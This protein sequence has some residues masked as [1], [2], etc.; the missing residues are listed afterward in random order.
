MIKYDLFD[1]DER[2]HGVGGFRLPDQAYATTE[3]RHRVQATDHRVLLGDVL[4]DLRF[5]AV[6]SHRV[7]GALPQGPSVVVPGAFISGA[8]QTFTR[9]RSISFQ[10]QDI[11]SLTVAAH[12]VRLGARVKTRRVDALDATNFGGTFQFQ[13]LADFANGTPLLLVRRAGN[14]AVSFNDT[15]ANLFAEMIF[16]PAETV[17]VT[18][19]LRYDWQ[20]RVPDWNNLGPRIAAAFAPQGSKTVYRAG[21]GVFYQSLSEDAVARALLF[22]DGGLREQSIVAPSFPSLPG[23]GAADGPASTWRLEPGMSAPMLVQASIAADRALWRKSSLSV[24]YLAIRSIGTLRARDVN[25]PLPG[26]L[27]RPDPSRLGVFQIESSGSGR[28]DALSTTFRG[29]LAGFRGTIQYTLSHATDEGAGVFD[30]PAD[31]NDLDAERGRADTDRRHR[32]SVAGTHGWLRDRL[33]LG[34][35]LAA[36]SGAP[37][38]IVTGADTNHDLLVNDRPSGVTR[39]LGNGPAFVQLDL[40]FTSVFRV[41][42]PPSKDPES[43]KREQT[44]NLEL[45]LDL[46]NALDRVNPTTFVG[47]TTSPLFGQA[48]AA[49]TPRTAQ[50]SLRYRF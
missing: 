20:A 4:N 40:R 33:R 29:R 36:W 19:G 12:Q 38:D 6:V 25:A 2:N 22:G 23:G 7:D 16:R 39:N 11:S 14:P 26:S 17:S 15:D 45:S 31:S 48:N 34:G 13:D 42:R 3:R 8:S 28:T 44:D 1:D 46:F 5:E 43:A 10:A 21:F 9:D 41:P 27:V 24:E 37:F 49:R 30:L 35:V 18:A 50:L 32:L 47:V